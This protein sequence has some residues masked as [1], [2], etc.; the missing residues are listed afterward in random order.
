MCKFL[1]LDD[2]VEVNIGSHGLQNIDVLANSSRSIGRPCNKERSHGQYI[3][4]DA[5]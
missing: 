3:I 2:S 4:L 1:V 5:S